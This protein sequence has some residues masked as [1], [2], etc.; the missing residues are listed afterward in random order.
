[1]IAEAPPQSIRKLSE[2]VKET[3]DVCCWAEADAA[4]AMKRRRKTNRRSMLIGIMVISAASCSISHYAMEEVK[5]WLA[6]RSVSSLTAFP[7]PEGGGSGRWRKGRRRKRR[8]IYGCNCNGTEKSGPLHLLHGQLQILGRFLTSMLF[9]VAG[10]PGQAAEKNPAAPFSP[11][12]F[13]LLLLHLLPLHLFLLA[14]DGMKPMHAGSTF[15]ELC[16]LR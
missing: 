2:G 15:K 11:L 4:K 16:T 13:F 6:S 9:V 7:V 1:M 5:D 10:R 3:A 8:K 12:N 14:K